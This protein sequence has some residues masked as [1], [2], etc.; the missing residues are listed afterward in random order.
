[1]T[2]LPYNSASI[3]PA[4]MV[5]LI[6]ESYFEEDWDNVDEGPNIGITHQW[7]IR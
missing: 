4:L 2:I 1:M 6:S 3:C 5:V 7:G